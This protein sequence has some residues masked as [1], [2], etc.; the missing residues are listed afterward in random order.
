[1]QFFLQRSIAKGV[2]FR[3]VWINSICWTIYQRR[4]ATGDLMTRFALFGKNTTK[5]FLHFLAFTAPDYISECDSSLYQVRLVK[6]VP[7]IYRFFFDIVETIP[8]LY[9][10]V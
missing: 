6:S 5:T 7:L 3:K 9:F 10:V 2:D 8:C 1:M 4:I